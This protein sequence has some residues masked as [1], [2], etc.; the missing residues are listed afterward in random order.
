MLRLALEKGRAGATYNA[1]AD[2]AVS[3]KEIMT[4][5]G[6]RMDLPVESK[7]VEEAGASIGF[8]AHVISMDNPTSG[9]K[10]QRELGWTP[11]GPGLLEDLEKNYEF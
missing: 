8:F 5:V 4:V 2:Q 11:T 1:V 9:E 10:T 7:S 3:I 6:K